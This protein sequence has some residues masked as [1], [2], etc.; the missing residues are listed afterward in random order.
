MIAIETPV[1]PTGQSFDYGILEADTNTQVHEIADL[2]PQPISR[3]STPDRPRPDQGPRTARAR[4]FPWSK[5]EFNWTERTARNFM[6]AARLMHG[7]GEII[8]A[9]PITGIYMLNS[10]ST[11]D[12]VRDAIVG[13]VEN[14]EVMSAK[15]IN[16]AIAEGKR[17]HAAE[18]AKLADELAE[19]KRLDRLT[20]ASRE[21]SK[22]KKAER[23]KQFETEKE[24]HAQREQ[25]AEAAADQA[26]AFLVEHLGADL[27]TFAQLV[28]TAAW[29]FETKL[30]AALTG[31]RS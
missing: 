2:D 7:K 12:A 1:L 17:A 5:A 24:E 28:K 22:K 23:Q 26:V 10:P 15:K 27:Q 30:F 8:S 25:A 13:R 4:A 21:R 16:A 9:L 18:Q 20:P 31:P 11:P 3:F 14:G 6:G 19:Q 29:R